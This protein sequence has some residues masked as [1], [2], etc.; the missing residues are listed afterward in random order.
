MNRRTFVKQTALAAGTL[1]FLPSFVMDEAYSKQELMGRIRP[2]LL[3]DNFNLRRAAAN[4]FEK[5]R[6][7]A[8]KEGITIYSAS[9]YRSYEHQNRIWTRKYKKYIGQGLSPMASI[10]KIVR[11][12][13][14]PGTSRHHWGTDLDMIDLSKPTP[15]D[16]LL[17]ANY[18]KGGV[19]E[20]LGDWLLKNANGYGFYEAY[21]NNSNRKGFEYEPWH[22]SYAPI[23]KPMLKDYLKLNIK[24]E[25]LG[26]GLLGAD[27][28]TSEFIDQYINENIKG[29]HPFL[30][31]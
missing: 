4:A 17:A 5:M 26:A 18:Q 10:K 9:S 23:A 3:G 6:Q 25:L 24:E 7:D 27:S 13:T 30:Q 22:Y 15:A 2:E 31:V 12:S 20:A 8:A 19:Y 1:M 28:F 21:T 29:I 16:A 11:Y 14:I